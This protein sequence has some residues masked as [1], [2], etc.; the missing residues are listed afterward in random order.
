MI[1]H[2]ICSPAFSIRPSAF[3]AS[4]QGGSRVLFGGVVSRR[5]QRRA[6]MHRSQ[7]LGSPPQPFPAAAAAAKTGIVVLG[8]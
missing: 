4:Q 1:A 5:E 8:V 6:G 3:P 7:P 2:N